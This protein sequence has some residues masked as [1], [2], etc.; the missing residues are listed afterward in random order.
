MEAHTTAEVKSGNQF[1]EKVIYL[2]NVEKSLTLGIID[3]GR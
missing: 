1:S 2:E 3:G